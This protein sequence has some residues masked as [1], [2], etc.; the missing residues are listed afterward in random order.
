MHTHMHKHCRHMTEVMLREI[1]H[2]PGPELDFAE[3]RESYSLAA[4]MALG[5]VTLGVSP[6]GLL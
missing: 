1:G 3:D 2:V 4:G 6:L 5:M